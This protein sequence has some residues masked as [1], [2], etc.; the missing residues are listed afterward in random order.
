MWHPAIWICP[1]ILKQPTTTAMDTNA[2]GAFRSRIVALL[3]DEALPVRKGSDTHYEQRS[4]FRVGAIW[5]QSYRMI[6]IQ[7]YSTTTYSRASLLI[8]QSNLRSVRIIN[9][10]VVTNVSEASSTR[11]HSDIKRGYSADRGDRLPVALPTNSG[12]T[13]L[14]RH[15]P[16]RQEKRRHTY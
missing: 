1:F 7:C 5:L 15:C 8:R 12:L 3:C 10:L 9:L 2:D 16:S 4:V 11:K 13:W 6:W 14:G